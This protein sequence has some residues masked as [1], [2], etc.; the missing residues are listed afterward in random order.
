MADPVWNNCEGATLLVGTASVSEVIKAEITEGGDTEEFSTW[1]SGAGTRVINKTETCEIKVS[2]KLT[3]ADQYVQRTST[4]QTLT[5]TG[6]G[7][8]FTGSAVITESTLPLDAGEKTIEATFT[9]KIQGDY[10]LGVNE[11]V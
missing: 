11:S 10:T 4:P 9:A 1:A 5:I 8:S 7:F 6:T 3:N 2:Y